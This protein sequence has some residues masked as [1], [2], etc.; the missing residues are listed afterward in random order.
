MILKNEN[1]K[2]AFFNPIE[3]QTLK[4]NLTSAEGRPRT[5]LMYAIEQKLIDFVT[6]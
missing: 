5:M 4:I 1:Y 2:D 3:T 6:C